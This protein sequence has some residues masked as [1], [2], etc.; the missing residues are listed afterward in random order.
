MR[1]RGKCAKRNIPS[2]PFLRVRWH[3]KAQGGPRRLETGFFSVRLGV[4][5]ERRHTR[6]SGICY[7][8]AVFASVS[9]SEGH[10]VRDAV[11]CKFFTGNV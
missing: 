11:T 8:K 4:I 1:G 5:V 7:R 10:D 9:V 3:P 2:A 6:I